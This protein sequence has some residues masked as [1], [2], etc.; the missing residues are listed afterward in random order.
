M[1]AGPLFTAESSSKMVGGTGPTTGDDDMITPI[2]K[3]NEMSMQEREQGLQDLHGVSDLQQENPSFVEESVAGLKM[4]LKLGSAEHSEDRELIKFLRSENF[5]TDRAA[6]RY[7]RFQALQTRLFGKPGKIKYS[8]LNE[9]DARFLQS[10]FMQLLPQRDRAGRAILICI[11]SIKKQ[12]GIPI[13]SEVRIWSVP[14][15]TLVNPVAHH[16]SLF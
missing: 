8:D 2:L 12:L 7:L 10:G 15:I 4:K 5:D 16:P 9:Q 3:L 11:S 6:A 1:R 14:T 13:E